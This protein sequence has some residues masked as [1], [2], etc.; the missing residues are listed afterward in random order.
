MDNQNKNNELTKEEQADLIILLKKWFSSV[1]LDK[2]HFLER[3]KVAKLLKKELG[4]RNR[5]ANKRA[6]K[7]TNHLIEFRYKKNR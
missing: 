1:D 4:I 3:N 6:P 7:K 5:W 2:P